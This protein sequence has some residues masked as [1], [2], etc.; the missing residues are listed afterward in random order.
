MKPNTKTLQ[1]LAA[2]GVSASYPDLMAATGIGRVHLTNIVAKLKQRKLVARVN[3]IGV[4]PAVF[5]ITS[6]GIEELCKSTAEPEPG[7]TMVGRAVRERPA[8]ARCWHT[9]SAQQRAA[10]A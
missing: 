4:E 5:C 7:E 8:L 3:A 1:V 6:A 10:T 2:I 9:D